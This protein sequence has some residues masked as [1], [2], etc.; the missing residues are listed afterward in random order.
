MEEIFWF[1]D[2]TIL[3]KKCYMYFPS[4]KYSLIENLN[5]IIRFFILYS[6]LCFVIYQKLDVLIPLALIMVISLIL[7]YLRSYIKEP[8]KNINETNTQIKHI[9]RTST[10]SNPMMNLSVMDYNNNKN[11]HIDKKITNE[12]INKNL[13]GDLFNDIIDV[14]NKNMFERNFY[15]TPIN[16]VP[17][18]QTEFAKW[19]YDKGPTCKEKTIECVNTIPERLSMGK[20]ASS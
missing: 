19:L 11:I 12:E 13:N 5:A 20:G 17:N 14:S 15:T 10:P 16:T 1:N 18:D 2:L 3:Y 4:S 7:Y 9:K 6:I 8:F